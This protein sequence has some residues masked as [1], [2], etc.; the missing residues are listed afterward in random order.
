MMLANAKAHISSNLF[1]GVGLKIRR[2]V[3]CSEALEQPVARKG[4][5]GLF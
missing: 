4:R 5:P 1:K 3:F 2:M